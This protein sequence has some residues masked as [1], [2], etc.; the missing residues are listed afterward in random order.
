VK[1]IPKSSDKTRIARCL[2]SRQPCQ[3]SLIEIAVQRQ[4][5]FTKQLKRLPRQGKAGV[6]A[7]G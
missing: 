7:A 4:C 3:Q 6:K 1:E 2:D 5:P